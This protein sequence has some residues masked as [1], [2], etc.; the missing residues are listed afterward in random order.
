LLFK[1]L[2]LLHTHRYELV[3]VPHFSVKE[4]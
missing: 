4:L 3:Q 1:P 2:F